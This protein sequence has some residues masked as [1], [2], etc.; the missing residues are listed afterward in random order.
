MSKQAAE[1]AYELGKK[2]EKAYMGCSQCVIAAIQDAFNIRDDAVFKAATGLTGGGGLCGD[3]SCG[4]YAGATLAL[5]ALSG[6]PRDDFEDRA[7]ASMINFLLVQRLRQR[8]IEE[9]GSVVCRDIQNKIFGRPFYLPD[10]DDLQKFE[11]AGGHSDKCPEVVGK[12]AQWAAEI[13]T[14]AGL[15]KK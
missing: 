1:K 15:A 2:Y 10:M 4:A 12:A 13:I 9:Y 7:G 8:F 6:R 3:G 11:K 5:S 14:E